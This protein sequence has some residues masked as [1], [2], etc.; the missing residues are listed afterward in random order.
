MADGEKAIRTYHVQ[1]NASNGAWP[2][3]IDIEADEME[4][5][6]DGVGFRVYTFKRDGEDVGQMRDNVAAWWIDRI[7]NYSAFDL[8]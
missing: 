4:I 8:E 1:L 5:D 7:V 3:V 2:P 6:V